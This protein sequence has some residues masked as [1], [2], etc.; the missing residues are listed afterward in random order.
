MQVP[1]LGSIVQYD[2]TWAPPNEPDSPR[3]FTASGGPNGTG[4][5]PFG[6]EEYWSTK[7]ISYYGIIYKVP[8]GFG[9]WL[10][11]AGGG[12]APCTNL[13]PG[14]AQAWGWTAHP[15]VSGKVTVEG[16]GGRPAA[17]V[18][19]RA[20]CPSG[21]T[22]SSNAEGDYGFPLGPGPCTIAPQLQSG[23]ASVPKQRVVEVGSQ[24][25]NNVDFQVPCGALAQGANGGSA[26][27]PD[28]APR[29]K[30]ALTPALSSAADC[31]QVFIKIVGPIPNVGTRS[32]LS[33]DNYAPSD[34]PMNFTKLTGA[35]HEAT[36]LVAIHQVGQQCVSG[37]ANILVTVLNKVTHEPAANT[38]VNVQLGAIDTEG[39]PN[40]HQQ[41]AQFL[42]LQ[43]GGP[44]QDCGTSLDGLKTDDNGQVRLLYW[45]PGELVPAHVELYAQACTA[46]TC[47]L[48]RAKSK[49][50]V[51]PYRIYHYEGELAPET[52]ADLV[53]M[54]RAD[55]VFDFFS[56]AAEQALE[57][58]AAFGIKIQ[59]VESEAVEL[60]LGPIGFAV[61][62]TIIDLTHAASELLDEVGLRDAF[63]KASGLSE[64]G[65][66]GGTG[67]S[68]TSAFWKVLAP[69]D[70]AYFDLLVL[71]G[72]KTFT[73]S[74]GWLW[75]LGKYLAEKYRKYS[76]WP[77]SG[78][79]GVDPLP[80]DL[81]VYETSYCKQYVSPEFHGM[82]EE[83]HCGPG[84]G[85][86]RSPNMRT[87]LCVLISQLVSPTC[88]ISYDAPIWVVSQK[89]LD[90]KLD[91]PKALVTSL[92]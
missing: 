72:G 9:A 30:A 50:T 57:R 74:S 4:S 86:S 84:Y 20:S 37:C 44:K 47:L 55:G 49:I 52:V 2:A 91:H 35:P 58:F 62:F 25:I 53:E 64:A 21:G 68:G 24:D 60:V 15:V 13:G 45:A 70:T 85:S 34:G 79:K 33:W 46:S 31:L 48:K 19:V 12:S 78:L 22:T 38:D 65:L 81:S 6:D 69:G 77:P 87:D 54:V 18:A 56:K 51:Y 83:A 71:N 75:D 26:T 7:E 89:G 1:L 67:P 92:P 3:A 23:E 16:P 28:Y 41:G 76:E 17:G 88:G 80:L 59:E 5:G 36:P 39:S 11:G 42:C 63:F 43:T 8:K 73:F 32:G 82:G 40:L 29:A 14:V 61:A 10:L 27:E 66:F 90:K